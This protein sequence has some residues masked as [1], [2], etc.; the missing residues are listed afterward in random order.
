[1]EK[2]LETKKCECEECNCTEEE[3]NCGDNCNCNEEGCHCGSECDCDDDCD[4][5]CECGDKCNCDEEHNCGCLDGEE[6]S[7]EDCECNY[8]E[9]LENKVKELEDRLL[10]EKAEMINYRKRKDED[11]ARMLKFGN[12]DLVTEMLPIID[13]FESA[14][15][16]DD[17][18]LED[19]VSK[20]LTGFKMIYCN[21]ISIL[22]KYDVKVIDGN[23]KPFDPTYHQAVIQEKSDLES[24]MV[25]EVLRK[26]YILKDK[27]IRPAMVKV[28]E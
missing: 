24:G 28:S 13:N 16:M 7:C 4:C 19:E 10:R 11:V 27:V 8:T 3:C 23:N 17:D 9:E 14:I 1:M 25:I 26:G 6:C 2:E 22:E 15:K 18:N 20:F 21:L 12:E 5:T